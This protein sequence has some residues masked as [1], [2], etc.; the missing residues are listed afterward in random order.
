MPTW[1]DAIL[2][3]LIPPAFRLMVVSDPDAL[4]LDERILH[5]LHQSRVEL[6]SFEDHVAFRY[7]Y[8]SEYRLRWDHGES[9]DRCVVVRSNLPDPDL[10]PY[11][12]LQAGH[13]VSISLSDLFPR[14][15]YRV[16]ETLDRDDL[17]ALYT[18]QAAI[19]LSA[20]GENETKDFVL[21]HVYKIAPD[22][23]IES[24]DLLEL[25]LNR[26]HRQHSAPSLLEN[27]LVQ[28]L[29]RTD[30]FSDWPLEQIVPDRDAFLRFLQERWPYFLDRKVAELSH[31]VWEPP[32][33]YGLEFGGPIDLPFTEVRSDIDT[34]FLDRIL[35]PVQ[36][37]GADVLSA[38]WVAV[39]VYID[40]ETDRVRRLDHVLQVVEHLPSPDARSSE[41]LLWARRWA[42][43]RRLQSFTA[44]EHD[45]LASRLVRVEKE[46]DAAFL[47]WLLK[48]YAALYSQPRSMVH[49]IPRMLQRHRER[50]GR[51]IALIVVDGL[52]LAQW[53][54]LRECL[55]E[56]HPE[57]HLEEEA[58]YAWIPTITPVSRQAIF[59]GLLP[60][61]FASSIGSTAREAELWRRAW[62][63]TVHPDA[64]AYGKVRGDEP[65]LESIETIIGPAKVQVVGL[66]INKVDDI[67]HGA[68]L[69]MAGMDGQVRLWGEQGYL[70]DLLTVLFQHGYDVFLTSDHGNVE[71]TGR[72]RPAKEGSVAAVRGQR[73]RVYPTQVLEDETAKQI[74]DAIRW[75]PNQGLPADYWPLLA[76]GRTAFISEGHRMVGHGGACIEEVVVPFISLTSV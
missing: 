5:Q 75:P 76:A 2:K 8:E 65:T 10:L 21:R 25:L 53:L 27:R 39:G 54:I 59:S 48:H 47:A 37:G 14:L 69:G 18:A 4:L 28:L 38:E 55:Q 61:Q 35:R 68:E 13:R 49:H 44:V 15:S 73:A 42:E 26:H 71:A 72:G 3:D 62:S 40:P 23:V 11:D 7:R 20:L 63:G 67:M 34:L 17:D 58:L 51:R 31:A 22:M 41:W 74:P 33:T 57:V 12:L 45:G 9:L 70:A 1:R 52:A 56:Q 36:H 60:Q 16:V 46:S 66:V 29:R 24:S 19:R 64:V 43:A 6:L 30:C 50:S 32:S